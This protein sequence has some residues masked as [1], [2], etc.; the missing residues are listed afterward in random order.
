MKIRVGF[1]SNSSSN[2]YIAYISNKK[3]HILEK[4]KIRLDKES[5]YSDEVVIIMYGD[6]ISDLQEVYGFEFDYLNMEKYPEKRLEVEEY[7]N[8][9]LTEFRKNRNRGK[10]IVYYDIPYYVEYNLPYLTGSDYW[11][12]FGS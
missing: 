1:V 4:E 9:D 12:Q 5:G 8:Y 6:T 11:V 3:R 10:L 2:S 7:P